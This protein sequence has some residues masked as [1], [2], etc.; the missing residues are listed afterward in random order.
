MH[1]K[2]TC[3]LYIVENHMIAA[4]CMALCSPGSLFVDVWYRDNVPYTSY[5]LSY[6][7]CQIEAWECGFRLGVFRLSLLGCHLMLVMFLNVS[8]AR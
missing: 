8:Q 7:V 3:H 5:L 6:A 4:L 1:T 2:G